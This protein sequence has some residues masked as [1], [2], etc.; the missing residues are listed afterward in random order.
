MHHKDMFTQPGYLIRRLHQRST[1]EFAAATEGLDVTQIQF[2]ILLV[3]RDCPGID[4][5]RISELIASDRTTIRQA[6]LLLETKALIRRAPGRH[7]RRTK[8]LEITETGDALAERITG[9]VSTLG[10]SILGGLS[11]RE[12]ATLMTLLI[13]LA[14]LE[15]ERAR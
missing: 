9:A 1:A 7:D 2:V 12:R 11:V 8:T 4:A 13:K 10:D 3:L 5:T 6:L 15:E 14:G